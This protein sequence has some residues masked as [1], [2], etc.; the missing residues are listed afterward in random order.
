MWVADFFLMPKFVRYT[1]ERLG[2]N[3]TIDEPNVDSNDTDKNVNK[4]ND[5]P[6]QDIVSNIQNNEIK[7]KHEDSKDNNEDNKDEVEEKADSIDLNDI[8]PTRNVVISNL[9]SNE[10]KQIKQIQQAELDYEKRYYYALYTTYL[11]WCPLMG[12]IGVYYIYLGKYKQFFIR[13]F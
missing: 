12:F 13:F 3:E 5:I 7:E 10:K 1:N 8:N 4:N 9:E 6:M 11:Y 2:L